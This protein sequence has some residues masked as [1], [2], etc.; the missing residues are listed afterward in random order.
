M[1]GFS[2]PVAHCDKGGAAMAKFA[3]GKIE[4]FFGP[5]ELGAPD[6]VEKVIV[7]SIRHARRSIDIAVYGLHSVPIVEALLDANRRLRRG[8]WSY[9]R[10]VIEQDWLVS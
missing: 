4:A 9:V 3:K 2:S 8:E 10:V 5:Q 6:D 1:T 7:D